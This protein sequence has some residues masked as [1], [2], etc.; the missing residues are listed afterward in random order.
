[1]AWRTTSIGGTPGKHALKVPILSAN[2]K[3]PNLASV[4]GNLL[5]KAARGGPDAGFPPEKPIS[6]TKLMRIAKAKSF[7]P[8]RAV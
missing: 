2:P 1:M 5:R 6:I 3:V 4:G 7:R 8:G